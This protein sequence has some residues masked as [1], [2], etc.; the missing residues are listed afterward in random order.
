MTKYNFKILLHTKSDYSTDMTKQ[1]VNYNIID[2]F[3]DLPYLA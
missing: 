2:I 3:R 1:T